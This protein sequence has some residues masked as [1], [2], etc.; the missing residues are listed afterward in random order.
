MCLETHAS[1]PH[2]PTQ[3]YAFRLNAHKKRVEDLKDEKTVKEH[4][5][6][7]RRRAPARR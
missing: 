4:V 5:E 7:Q 1:H 6:F 2:T 3:T